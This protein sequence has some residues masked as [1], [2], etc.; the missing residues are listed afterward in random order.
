MLDTRIKDGCRSSEHN[1]S[2]FRTL[3]HLDIAVVQDKRMKRCR[4]G[5]KALV[6]DSVQL[7][8]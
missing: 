7:R 8:C 4:T 5:A 6:Q 1:T 2:I 3:W